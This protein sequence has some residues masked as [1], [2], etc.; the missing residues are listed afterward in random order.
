MI[1]NKSNHI[2]EYL[3]SSCTCRARIFYQDFLKKSAVL[4]VVMSSTRVATLR[5]AVTSFETVLMQLKNQKNRSQIKPQKLSTPASSTAIAQQERVPPVLELLS[6]T[7]ISGRNTPPRNEAEVVVKTRS[8]EDVP[9]VADAELV[10]RTTGHGRRRTRSFN[11]SCPSTPTPTTLALNA[12]R[13]A[14]Q[15]FDD[16]GLLT[17]S[18]TTPLLALRLLRGLLSVATDSESSGTSANRTTTALHTPKG[19]SSAA[20]SRQYP[21]D[22]AEGCETSEKSILSSPSPTGMLSSPTALDGL[23]LA[24]SEASESRLAVSDYLDWARLAKKQLEILNPKPASP[25]KLEDH[26]DDHDDLTLVSSSKQDKEFRLDKGR[27]RSSPL[28]VQALLSAL[29]M[30]DVVREL[31]KSSNPLGTTRGT[32]TKHGIDGYR[33]L[34]HLAQIVGDLEVEVDDNIP[35]ILTSKSITSASNTSTSSGAVLTRKH[36]RDHLQS[37]PPLVSAVAACVTGL[38]GRRAS[39]WSTED[40]IGILRVFERHKHT[41]V[42]DIVGQEI[43][44]RLARRSVLRDEGKQI[45]G[46]DAIEILECYARMGFSDEE[47]FLDLWKAVRAAIGE[48]TNS[49]FQLEEEAL[50]PGWGEIGAAI[51]EYDREECRSGC[52]TDLADRSS[53]SGTSTQTHTHLFRLLHRILSASTTLESSAGF[54]TLAEVTE[55]LDRFPSLLQNASFADRFECLRGLTVA[56]IFLPRALVKRLSAPPSSK[57]SSG[58][59]ARTSRSSSFSRSRFNTSSAT[60]TFSLDVDDQAHQALPS[61]RLFCELAACYPGDALHEETRKFYWTQLQRIVLASV[62][63]A[64]KKRTAAPALLDDLST[65]ELPDLANLKQFWCECSCSISSGRRDTGKNTKSSTFL[66]LGAGGKGMKPALVSYYRTWWMLLWH[67][68]QAYATAS[69]PLIERIEARDQLVCSLFGAWTRGGT[70]WSPGVKRSAS[71]WNYAVEDDSCGSLMRE[72]CNGVDVPGGSPAGSQEV[73]DC[74]SENTGAEVVDVDISCSSSSLSPNFLQASPTMCA[75]ALQVLVRIEKDLEP[76]K[77]EKKDE[78][79][80]KNVVQLLSDL[81]FAPAFEKLLDIYPR[82]IVLPPM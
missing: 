5:Q 25:R 19:Q 35:E 45:S 2:L 55:I 9:P 1:Y 81:G 61:L 18:K 59:S 31:Q 40:L 15:A 43:R 21:P 73:L 69:L 44:T 8:H 60:S 6:P 67:T 7:S 42:I 57:R 27:E 38:P 75:R 29:Q 76:P 58:S 16:Y 37:L 70:T 72:R 22:R 14:V 26:E 4:V 50:P 11:S 52:T 62:P 10:R 65:M 68:A 3:T 51:R 41:L 32:T 64:S 13:N 77:D 80:K 23:G 36:S 82:M 54:K 12:A 28:F 74:S 78:A 49:A 24:L 33:Q 17:E 71:N 63:S 66:G 56:N 39:V 53:S 79:L 20:C 46:Y 47:L 34:I 30:P 48:T